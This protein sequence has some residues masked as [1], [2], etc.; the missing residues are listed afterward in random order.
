[1]LHE[2]NHLKELE[3]N[4]GVKIPMPNFFYIEKYGRKLEDQMEELLPV[5]GK[6]EWFMFKT[7][8]RFKEGGLLHNFIIELEKHAKL[9]KDYEECILIELT[10]DI[11]LNEECSEFLTYLKMLEEKIY[12]LFAIKQGKDTAFIQECMEQYFFIRV[13]EAREYS[14]EEQW[15]IIQKTCQEFQ[16]GISCEAKALLIKGIEK[17]G[18]KP[19]EQ[20][21]CRLKNN[22]CSQIYELLLTEESEKIILQKT[23]EGILRK[24]DPAI[25][26]RHVIGFCQGGLTYE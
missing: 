5:L 11:H 26:K 20:V 12:F 8:C 25:K 16:V 1:M 2:I 24:L 22:V 6:K 9:G 10:E 3:V 17:R 23:A 14:I 21:M 18:W 13:I 19:E 7:D 4:T 15:N